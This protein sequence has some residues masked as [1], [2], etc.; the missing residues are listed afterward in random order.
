MC[1]FASTIIHNGKKIILWYKKSVPISLWA[2]I[3]FIRYITYFIICTKKHNE[4]FARRRTI[5][6]IKALW[7]FKE[8]IVF[9]CFRS[10]IAFFRSLSPFFNW[11]K[12]LLAAVRLPLVYRM[13]FARY[14]W[15]RVLKFFAFFRGLKWCRREEF[16]R[17]TIVS[18]II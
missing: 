12:C 5:K 9:Y 2:R 6:K 3:L 1:L 15:L 11:T 7:Q 14:W 4:F 17:S 16:L 18:I 10:F 13:S 8:I